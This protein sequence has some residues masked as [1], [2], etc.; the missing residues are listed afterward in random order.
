M[1]HYFRLGEDDCC[2]CCCFFWC[3]KSRARLSWTIFPI[4]VI[5]NPPGPLILSGSRVELAGGLLAPGLLAST[6][7]DVLKS[8]FGLR[9]CLRTNVIPVPP[10]FEN[11][12]AKE[13]NPVN[14]NVFV[15]ANDAIAW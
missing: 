4:W 12:R 2:C 5:V 10:E 9:F 8:A 14:V 3:F 6:T 7:C 13:L 1:V 15:Q 11:R